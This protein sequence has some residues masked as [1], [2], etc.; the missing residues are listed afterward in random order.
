MSCAVILTAI[1][2]EYMAV[3]AHLT[4]LKEE[5][6]P[7]GTIYERGK[8][9]SHGQEWEVGIV[10]TGAGNS[11]AAVEA[12]RAIA[13]FNP[14]VILFV[15][16]AGGIK[17]VKL[18]DVVAAT[19]VYGYESGKVAETFRPRPDVGISTYKMI[20]RARA[21]AKKTDWLAR[22]SS[23]ASPKVFVAPIAA[24]EKVVANKE[25]DLF[26]FLQHNYGDALAVEMEGR[27]ILQ[28]AHAN[29]QVSALII[30]GISD[31]IDGK[32][33]ADEGGYQEIAAG[34]ASAFAFEVLGKLELN[35]PAQTLT[36]TEPINKTKTPKFFAYDEAWVGRKS[37]INDLT[38]KLKGSCRLLI[39]VGITGIGKTALG[40]RLAVELEDWF[41]DWNSYLQE[42]FDNEEQT[43]DFGSVA[44]RL[45]EK[46]G[47]VVTPDDRKDTQRLMYRLVRHLQENRYLIQIDSL[48]RILQGNEEEGWSDFIDEFWVK[49]FQT[50]LNVDTCE[51][52]FI[53]TSQDLPAQIP[54]IGTRS[55]NFWY[56]QALSG[57]DEPEQ[58]ALFGKT[59]L[60]VTEEAEGKP[61]LERIGRAYEGHPLALRVIAGEI[62]TRPFYGNVIGYWNKYGKEVEEV[63]KA[64]EEAKTKGITAS[65]DDQF[66][67]HKYTRQLRRNVKVRLEKAFN[68]LKEG[69][70]EAYL[71]LC[72]SSVYRCEVPEDFWLSHLEDWDID[73]DAQQRAL[74]ALRDRYLVEESVDDNNEYLLRQHNLIRAVSLEHLRKL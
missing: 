23:S 29:Q 47:E 58:L 13:Y 68:R 64:I 50:W 59:G 30:R 49:F 3:R 17:D 26:K 27:G 15:G 48:E 8:F 6:H 31:L 44:A 5:M 36:T 1:P 25:S 37:L 73:E 70:R 72:E 11:P 39:L 63:E 4:D 22:V 16:V 67:L 38:N 45:L 12:E 57:L 33:E 34:H 41:E 61:Y 32:S 69:V 60:D 9:S 28:A 55:Q 40:E 53:L 74:D 10:E 20:Q 24:G 18:G 65:A 42:N 7:Q 62:V 19:K 66:N 51:S 14:D 43:A 52:C 54:I 71:L 46:C 21:E 35:S 2:S 56:C